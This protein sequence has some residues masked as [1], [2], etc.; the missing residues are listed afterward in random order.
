MKQLLIFLLVL[1]SFIPISAQD[2]NTINSLSRRAMVIYLQGNNGFYFRSSEKML[3][4]VSN[5]QKTYAFDKKAQILYVLTANAN[6]AITLD[7]DC[8][9]IIK[10][11]KAI[12]Q[13][14]G[15]EL[16]KLIADYS[17]QL[18]DKF[19]RLNERRR[20]FIQDS[21]AKVRKVSI[22]RVRRHE[23][24]LAQVK[25]EADEYR[26]THGWRR[27][28]TNYVSLKC[29]ICDESFSD[30]TT[31]CIGI[32]N[33]S[34]Y[35][36]TIKKEDLGLNL[37]STH[38]AKIPEELASNK[39]FQYHYKVFKDRLTNDTVDYSDVVNYLGWEYY[40]R[41]I[42]KVKRLAPFGFVDGWGWNDEYSVITFYIN[43]VNTNPKTIRYITVYFKVTN[44]VGDVRCTGHF[45]G[46]GPVKQWD[47]GSWSWDDSSYFVAGDA[48]NMYITKIV[49]TWMNGKTQV[50]SGRYLQFNSSDEDD[51]DDS[52]DD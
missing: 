25:K 22:E 8:A 19:T 26:N 11:N 20:L 18:D 23:Q 6:I 33:D 41:Y 51:S 49:L 40:Y 29:T 12:P 15:D 35:F 36:Y 17:K 5:V 3:N 38:Q 32:K 1:I 47:K 45:K 7:K 24:Y 43:Y 52:D 13:L 39:D 21:L 42:S 4:E 10:K 30:D 34:I 2:F 50:V 48:T 46:T 16:N 27:V 9:K 31:N 28:P 37:L 44:D 14:K